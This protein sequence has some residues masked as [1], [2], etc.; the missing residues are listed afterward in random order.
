M[1]AVQLLGGSCFSHGP[2]TFYKGVRLANGLALKLGSFFLTK[3]WNDA[4][5]VCIGELQLLWIDNRGPNTPLASL[6]LYFLPENT[7]EGRK[8]THGEDEVLSISEKVVIRVHDLATCLSPELEWTYGRSNVLPPTPPSSLDASPLHPQTLTNPGLDFSDVERH[9][10]DLES[11]TLLTRRSSGNDLLTQNSR[12]QPKVVVLSY[13]RYCRYRALIRRLEGSESKWASTEMAAALGG[14]FASNDTKILFCRDT[15][16]YPDLETHEMLC[17]HLAPK[18][19]GRPRRKRKKRDVSPAGESSNESE[20]SVASSATASTFKGLNTSSTIEC[21]TR[22]PSRSSNA[23]TPVKKEKKIGVEEKRFVAEIHQFMTARKTPLGKMPLL[24]YKQIDLYMFYTTVQELGGYDKVSA[25]RLWKSIYDSL[26]GNIGSTSAATITRKHYEKL[27]LPYER[28]KKGLDDEDIKT[29]NGGR[30]SKTPS[31]EASD[32]YPDVKRE[33]LSPGA[34]SEAQ[35][36]TTEKLSPSHMVAPDTTNKSRNETGKSSS[37]RSVRVKSERLKSLNTMIAGTQQQQSVPNSPTSLTAISSSSTSSP[38]SNSPISTTP[39]LERQLNSPLVSNQ[40]I[41]SS[42]P[43]GLPV[44]ASVTPT[45]ATLTPLPEKDLKEMKLDSKGKENIPLYEKDKPR[46]PELVDL[47]NDAEPSVRDKIIV[48]IVPNFKKRKLEILRE[49]GLDITTVDNDIRPSV[50]QPTT[51]VTTLNTSMATSATASVTSPTNLWSDKAG[52]K[53]FMPPT[54]AIIPKLINVTVTPDISHILPLEAEQRHQQR[55]QQ[56]SPKFP[57]SQPPISKSPTNRVIN[58][59]SPHNSSLLQLYADANVPAPHSISA[60]LTQRFGAESV[61]TAN[62]RPVPPPK[63]TQGISIFGNSC[64]SRRVYG[65]PNEVV[66]KTSHSSLN[67]LNSSPIGS[68]IMY[69]GPSTSNRSSPRPAD[70]LDLSRKTSSQSIQQPELSRA[71]LEIVKVP[72]IP[73]PKPLNLEIS[74][75]R[76]ERE[77]TSPK[78]SQAPI[79]GTPHTLA[80]LDSRSKSQFI[81]G[82]AVPSTRTTYT[83]PLLEARTMVSSNLEIT[84]VSPRKSANNKY[85]EQNNYSTKNPVSNPPQQV[86]TQNS[87]AQR[88][89]GKLPIRVLSSES[90]TNSYQS[91]KLSGSSNSLNNSNSGN[92]V[93]QR[94][95]PHQQHPVVIPNIPNLSHLSGASNYNKKNPESVNYAPSGDKRK[96]DNKDNHYKNDVEKKIRDDMHSLATKQQNRETEARRH[97]APVMPNYMSFPPTANPYLHQ[98]ASNIMTPNMLPPNQTAAAVAAAG[99]FLPILDPMSYPYFNGLLPGPHLPPSTNLMPFLPPEMTAYYK[100]ML[101]D[102]SQQR[103]GG[104]HQPTPPTS[105]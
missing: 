29:N 69:Q 100:H 105:K 82:K 30:L 6:R 61:T 70:V 46:S 27:L 84:L 103:S 10:K 35:N 38:T 58:V 24:G 5:L 15:F 20:A 93:N 53:S 57:P 18:L 23:S 63:V 12:N 83:D 89:N 97:S 95:M 40:V 17:N 72:V 25:N 59:G 64:L 79:S 9:L 80:G 21:R 28:S 54:N 65:N 19:K 11:N 8:D 45:A 26:G 39:A 16:D 1:E 41:P 67:M 85:P 47:E 43:P 56:H 3:L 88:A 77:G 66:E 60:Q 44:N 36:L 94:S 37:L 4:D 42:S 91:R 31:F 74:S 33:C 101:A 92:N 76:K 62:G 87:S 99:K 34:T 55:Q 14:F 98:L 68:P 48:P 104:V 22:P 2:Y 50:I 73:R 102:T 81:T 32:D 13:A 90:L 49:G 51:V 7:P 71:N 96:S 52:E 78:L 75:L 86:L